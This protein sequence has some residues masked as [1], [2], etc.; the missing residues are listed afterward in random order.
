MFTFNKCDKH[1]RLF[2][3]DIYMHTIK[4]IHITFLET[5]RKYNRKIGQWGSCWDFQTLHSKQRTMT[6]RFYGTW[7]LKTCSFVRNGNEVRTVTQKLVTHLVT[8]ACPEASDQLLIF[9]GLL[10]DRGQVLYLF[11]SL[12]CPEYNARDT[13]NKWSLKDLSKCFIEINT[14]LPYDLYDP[15]PKFFLWE[16][17]SEK[18]FKSLIGEE[19]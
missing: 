19:F 6:F 16:F 2:S 18:Q 7:I 12:Y 15:A 17:I 5:P 14:Y 1:S 13:L 8:L 9:R 4:L 3:A 10:G 11:W